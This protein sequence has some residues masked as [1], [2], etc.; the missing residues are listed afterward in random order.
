MDERPRNLI[1][2]METSTPF[3]LNDAIHQ[4]REALSQS[5]TFQGE[6][7]QELESH[8]RDSISTLQNRGLDTEEAFLIATRRLGKESMLELEFTKINPRRLW[9]DRALWMLIGIQIWGL[10]THVCGSISRSALFWGW[11]AVHFYFKKGGLFFPV[12]LFSLV[13]TLSFFG[14]L[15]ILWWAV[16]GK[17]RSWGSRLA[18][19]LHSRSSLIWTGMGLALLWLVVFILSNLLQGLLAKH[20]GASAA[21]LEPTEFY[22][23]YSYSQLIFWSIQVI[24][25]VFLTLEIA[26]RRL[27]GSRT[28]GDAVVNSR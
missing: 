21:V 14:S 4:W 6:N 19:R 23:S 15:V 16:F 10:A 28:S 17:G 8:L 11:P 27:E 18:A 22:T 5:P 20:L 1:Q 13:Q 12:T 24:A 3:D 7:L 26:R 2:T 9:L 25:L